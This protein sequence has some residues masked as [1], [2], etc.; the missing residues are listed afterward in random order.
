MEVWKP[1]KDFEGYYEASSYGN[2]KSLDRYKDDKG[3]PVF[4]KGRIMKPFYQRDGYLLV[5]LYKDGVSYTKLVH[6]IIAETFIDNPNNLPCVN[7][8]DEVKD[9][10]NVANLE[11]CDYSYNN[12]YG[13]KIA[14]ILATKKGESYPED[15]Y[16]GYKIYAYDKKGELVGTYNSINEA[17][18]QL[19]V[20]RTTISEALRLRDGKTTKY[21]FRRI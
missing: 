17:S 16:H 11:W 19:G 18:R 14:R 20:K 2:I 8:K 13:T 21:D 15:R 10:N 1:I 5:D 6:R 4:I 3:T 7:H 12:S 9:N